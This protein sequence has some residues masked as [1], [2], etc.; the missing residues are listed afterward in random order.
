MSVQSLRR[1]LAPAFSARRLWLLLPVFALGIAYLATLQY[2]IN[3]SEHAYATDV[4]EIQNA[5]PRW[6]TI[7][8]PGYPLYSV[9]GSTF[10]TLLRFVGVPPAAGASLFSMAWALLAAGLLFE[11]ACELGAAP[12]W[13]AGGALIAGLATSFWLNASVAEIHTM[14]MVLLLAIT[15]S[16]LR[17]ARLGRRA[18]LL[19][20]AVALTQGVMHQR[21]LVLT[22]PAVALLLWPRR[23]ELLGA[24]LP[25]LGVSLVAPLVYLYLPVRAWQGSDWTF[26]AVG[27][28]Q[29]FLQIFLDTKVERIVATPQG[30]GGWWQRVLMLVNLLHADIWWP[31]MAVG[32]GGIWL[33]A[34]RPGGWRPALAVTLVWLPLVPLA[35]VI[36]EN[37]VSDA[38]LAVKLP[39]PLFAGVGWALLTGCLARRG[40]RT[41]LA[42]L[43][44]LGLGGSEIYAHRGAVVEVTRDVSAARTIA[45]ASQVAQQGRSTP[46]I[47]MALWGHKYWALTYARAYEGRL[48]GLTIVDHNVDLGAVLRSGRRVMTFSETFYVLPVSHWEE[49]A[50]K[51]RLS[52]PAPGIVELMRAVE[53]EAPGAA[54]AGFDLGNGIA[55][56][57]ADMV[58]YDDGQALLQVTWQARERVAQDYSVAVH[59][60]RTR[61]P[62]G[63]E[64]ILAQADRRHPVDGWYPT[65]SWSAGETVPD[66]Y[67]LPA[68]QGGEPQ[69]VRV[70][71]YRQLADG[72]FQNSAWLTLPWP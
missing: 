62:R 25:V 46:V 55:I 29:G 12:A 6:G 8:Y 44:V 21:S 68:P 45:L 40:V 70:G 23:R 41:L 60:L 51:L 28:W 32:L 66:C 50:G 52:S 34:R 47:F 7:H 39:L 31:V 56:L 1:R 65:S 57:Q 38:L 63:P 61:T 64:D 72:S 9:L 5:L 22:L 35:L 26:G 3:G 15:L 69:W 48:P 13:A 59:V 58:P 16:S 43:I 71:L 20:L 24:A 30:L 67:L 17:Y 10:V 42:G 18:D 37:R 14:A 4:G 27:T 19:W 49:R 11:I 36:W 2:T 54:A 53:D 33:A